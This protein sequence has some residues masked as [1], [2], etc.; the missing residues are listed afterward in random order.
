MKNFHKK[1]LR[2]VGFENFSFFESAILN[3]FVHFFSFFLPHSG[4]GNGVSRSL[5]AV[6]NSKLNIA[7]FTKNFHSLGMATYEKRIP[8][9]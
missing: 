2:L 1:V 4:N 6:Y 9:K 7:G 8:R 3:F 5:G